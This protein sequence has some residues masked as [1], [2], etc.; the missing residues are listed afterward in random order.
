ASLSIR[1]AHFVQSSAHLAASIL[2]RAASCMLSSSLCSFGKFDV[3]RY[4]MPG[5]YPNRWSAPRVRLGIVGSFLLALCGLTTV[6]LHLGQA[7]DPPFA[8]QVNAIF[9]K[10]DQLIVAVALPDAGEN[11]GVLRV[12]VIDP[13]GKSV[14]GAQQ[15]VPQKDRAA[16]RFSLEASQKD[17]IK[18]KL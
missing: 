12:E 15:E 5:T 14:A 16:Y 13:D 17:T 3:R 8:P 7:D 2:W 10:A 9:G 11:K 4:S 1:H 6:G 18:L